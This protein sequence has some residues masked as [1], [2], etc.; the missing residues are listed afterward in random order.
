MCFNFAVCG[1]GFKDGTALSSPRGYGVIGRQ[2]R[3]APGRG[4]IPSHMSCVAICTT[5]SGGMLTAG[6]SNAGC[7]NNGTRLVSVKNVRNFVLG[8]MFCMNIDYSCHPV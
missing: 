3:I 4:I 1:F 5:S 2:L 7:V 6:V 8:E